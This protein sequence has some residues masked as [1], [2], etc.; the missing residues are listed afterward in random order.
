MTSKTSDQDIKIPKLKLSSQE[1]FEPSPP[2]PFNPCPE[3]DTPSENLA[4]DSNPSASLF[5]NKNRILINNFNM[6]DSTA[7]FG[8]ETPYRTSFS[9]AM[10]QGKTPR[11]FRNV[12]E[13]RGFSGFTEAISED[14]SSSAGFR[15]EGF[16]G[17]PTSGASFLRKMSKKKSFR[18]ALDRMQTFETE[19][20]EE[21][22]DLFEDHKEIE[23]EKK[24]SKGKIFIEKLLKS[25]ATNIIVGIVTVF[26]LFADDV[27]ALV[28]LEVL[29]LTFD[30]MTI[31]TIVIFVLEIGFALY[32][33]EEY[34]WSMFFWLDI[35]STA[36]MV[37][38]IEFLIEDII[39]HQ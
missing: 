29:D 32:V 9:I 1:E 12:L 26:A 17:T 15:Q 35:F 18:N 20:D 25:M 37:F 23:K 34:L 13:N 14:V 2:S 36:S 27:R 24:K 8:D 39:P 31:V 10:R 3:I 38:D 30:V 11:R 22:I 4:F 33:E 5:S 6:P 21:E 28:H 16:E 19:D 7:R